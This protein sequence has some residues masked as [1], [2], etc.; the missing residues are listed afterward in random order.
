MTVRITTIIVIVVV[1]VTALLAEVLHVQRD[2]DQR[3]VQIERADVAR[4]QQN[5]KAEQAHICSASLKIRKPLSDYID[6]TVKQIDTA[7]KEGIPIIPPGTPPALRRIQL[8]S[9][10]NLRVL[11]DA[12]KAA[13]S[14][15][16]AATE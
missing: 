8:H 14:K 12:L 6:S 7:K 2:A 4:A 10:H 5:A 11:D 15:G 9:F 16:C 1:I 3:A 13:T